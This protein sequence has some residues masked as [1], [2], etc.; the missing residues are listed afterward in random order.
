MVNFINVDTADSPSLRIVKSDMSR[1]NEIRK[2]LGGQ[3]AHYVLT[4]EDEMV[5]STISTLS[6]SKNNPLGV[7]VTYF[8]PG[9]DKIIRGRRRLFISLKPYDL[10]LVA[11]YGRVLEAV[12]T[13]QN[14]YLLGSDTVPLSYRIIM[15]EIVIEA[16]QLISRTGKKEGETHAVRVTPDDLLQ[17]AETLGGGRSDLFDVLFWQGNTWQRLDTNAFRSLIDL[18]SVAQTD[19]QMVLQG[20]KPLPAKGRIE[21]I[22]QLRK[23]ELGQTEPFLA[24]LMDQAGDSAKGVREAALNVLKTV[25][26]N[27]I[28][29]LVGERLSKGTTAVRE[30]MVQ[31]LVSLGTESADATLQDHLKT[32]KTARIKA[33]IETA[34]ASRSVVAQDAKEG[35]DDLTGYTALDGSWVEIPRQK[36]LPEPAPIQISAAERKELEDLVKAEN[37]RINKYN[38]ENKG[39]KYFY[40]QQ[41]L[42][43]DLVQN[44]IHTLETPWDQ[45]NKEKARTALHLLQY[46][47]VEWTKKIL[48]RLSDDHIAAMTILSAYHISALVNPYHQTFFAA[49]TM[50]WLNGPDGD[51][52]WLDE[53]GV[54]VGKHIQFGS[55]QNRMNRKMVKGDLL[56]DMIPSD[57]YWGVSPDDLP[58]R[59]LWP[60][61]AENLDV[62]DQAF[63][64]VSSDDIKISRP[65]AIRYLMAMPKAPMRYFAPL[66]EVATG[67]AKSGKADARQMLMDIPEVDDRLTALLD[68]SRQAVRAGVAEWMGTRGRNSAIKPLKTRLKKEKSELARAAILT[69][70]QQLGENLESYL[71]PAALIKEAETGLKKAKFDKLAWLQLDHMPKAHFKNGKPVPADVLR[72]WV[73]M[74]NKLKQPG[75]NTLFELY[76]DQLAPDDSMQFSS[77][78]LNSWVDYDTARPTDQEANDYAQKHAQNRVQ[79]YQRWMK[80]Y[81]LER[82]IADLKSEVK[83]RYLNSGAANKGILG[84][85]TRTPPSTAADLVRGYLRNHGSRTSQASSLLEVLAAKGDPVSL[86]VVI[87]AATRLKQKGVQAFA[88]ELIQTV[89]DRMNWS[90]DE[91][92]DRTVPT[93]GLDDDGILELPCG[94]EQKI[95]SAR[96]GDDLTLVLTN[97]D[98]K[99]VKALSSGTDDDTKA[100]KKQLSASKKEIKQ[101]IAMQTARLYEALCAERSWTQEAWQRDFYDHPV[102]RRLIERL[103]WLGLDDQDKVVTSFRPTAEGEFTDV[104]DEMV[105]PTQFASIRLA[106]GALMDQS[107]AQAWAQHLEDYEVKPLFAQFGRDLLRLPEAQKDD[108]RITDREGWVTDTFTIRGIANKLGY[109]R[110]QAED[111]GFFYEYIKTFSSAGLA[112]VI[113]FSGNCLPEEN[114]A[115]A[116]ISL[117]FRKWDGRR[118]KGALK[119]SE[120]PPVLLSECWNDYYAMAA[121]ASHDPDWKKKMPW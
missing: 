28:E 99:V 81:T 50:E 88:G 25:P 49:R 75:G 29:S 76:F 56:R 16:R 21:F 45:L 1:L 34:M 54:K 61:M 102:M 23:W 12:G 47:A 77:W 48:P 73:F 90:L 68:D 64:L 82:A 89:A 26:A 30:G 52:R 78:I 80:D 85:A 97:P 100:S 79:M 92:S 94:P 22:E 11:R 2:G 3:A 55:W 111:G 4:G 87:A 83:S 104:N 20:V 13:S 24:F 109:E 66:L 93:A 115:A 19:P 8:S 62:F 14:M 35:G 112:A 63:G 36:P 114:V 37:D 72:W 57:G 59:A 98:G 6:A 42:P 60:Y 118:T 53:I 58:V 46:K 5:L 33:V 44:A 86:Q 32:E 9:A 108:T 121:R 120:V 41:L 15:A 113:E 51:F 106:H 10:D 116:M 105:D 18:K 117:E 31:L 67:T 103:V 69:A 74:A 101:V 91:L 70:L 43:K 71:G 27:Q 95:Y 84:L 38:Q 119:L 65:A 96:L 7:A 39:K 110:G 107:A 17:L 40:K